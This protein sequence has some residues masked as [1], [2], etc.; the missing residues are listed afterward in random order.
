MTNSNNLRSPLSRITTGVP[1]A[2]RQRHTVCLRLLYSLAALFLAAAPL[3]AQTSDVLN[4]VDH[5]NVDFEHSTVLNTNIALYYRNYTGDFHGP[6]T[7]SGNGSASFHLFST[8]RH[9]SF[10]YGPDGIIGWSPFSNA[11]SAEIVLTGGTEVSYTPITT[12]NVGP[13]VSDNYSTQNAAMTGS[14][15]AL[16]AYNV[17]ERTRWDF[18][19]LSTDPSGPP[20]T[21]GKALLATGFYTSLITTNGGIYSAD[22]FI[23][24]PNVPNSSGGEPEQLTP[25][26]TAQGTGPG[27]LSNPTAMNV[28]PDGLLYVLDYGLDEAGESNGMNR[29]EKFDLATGEYHGQFFLPDGVTVF[30]TSLAISLEGHIYLGDG[31]GG[32]SV[33]DLDGTLLGTFH[34]P[35]PD[36]GWVDGGLIAGSPAG[37]GSFLQYDGLGN[38]FTYVEGQGFFMYHDPSYIAVPEPSTCAL[39]IGGLLGIVLLRRRRKVLLS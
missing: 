3:D 8:Q 27:E 29:I 16:Y 32:G 35:A 5:I 14:R 13:N 31:L 11:F 37:V 7:Y 19:T 34:P 36:P 21:P 20:Y 10:S 2:R 4:Y 26:V 15:N 33:F 38:I 25:L 1:G 23:P 17:V 22:T 18:R 30:S 9:Y 28:G 12:V 39:A 24:G 6:P